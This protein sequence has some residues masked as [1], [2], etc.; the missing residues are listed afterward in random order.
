M[1]PQKSDPMKAQEVIA[2]RKTLGFTRNALAATLGLTPNVI[3]AW[4]EGAL[5]VP[6][7]FAEQLRYE[8]AAAN[9][10]AAVDGKG[11][12]ECAWDKAW[13]NEP[14]PRDLQS[15]SEHLEVR[16]KHQATCPVCL[17]NGKYI[18][19]KI[20]QMPPSPMPTSV[21]T[22]GAIAKRID[23]LPR[24]AQPAAWMAMYF[25][26]YSIVRIFIML[27]R[28]SARPQ[29]WFVPLA[30]LAMSVT[31]GGVLGLIYGGLR[32]LRGKS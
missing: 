26:A 17:A 10:K 30:G 12:E 4:E 25:G 13:Q 8:A 29:Y 5:D 22:V 27:P 32:E 7:I 3:E 20:A 28:L 19:G 9:L 31:I 15:Q 16:G 14:L 1:A 18:A 24:W 2:A 21:R 11:L 6:R 23:N